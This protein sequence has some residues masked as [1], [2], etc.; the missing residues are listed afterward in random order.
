MTNLRV[1]TVAIANLISDPDNARKH[2]KKNI[3]SIVGSLKKFGQRKPIVATAGNIVIAGNGTLQAANEI[4]WELADIGF[5][6]LDPSVG[7]MRQDS[8]H[9]IN[10]GDWTFE[11]KCPKCGFEFND[12]K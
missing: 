4:G 9:E 1:E 3:D 6:K 11:H 8:T 2:S 7:D 12:V 10:V 5:P